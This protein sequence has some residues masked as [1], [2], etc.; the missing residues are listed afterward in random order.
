MQQPL[1]FDRERTE[2]T[3]SQSTS[4]TLLDALSD[5]P[6]NLVWTLTFVTSISGFLFGYDTGYI[7]SVLVSIGSDLN[8]K[9]LSIKQREYISSATSLG[10]LLSS[11]LT[12]FLADLIGR[13]FTLILSDLLF[14]IGALIQYFTYDLNEMIIGRLIMGFGVGLGSLC[15]PL[16]ISEL[17]PSKF[18]GRLVTI[19]C[20]AI[21]GG[22]L[23][24]YSIGAIFSNLSHGWRII[25]LLS[26]LPCIIQFISISFFLPDSPRYLI[27]KNKFNDAIIVLKKI[28]PNSSDSL[29][30]SNVEELQQLNLLWNNNDNIFQKLLSSWIELF[31]ISSN[32]RSLIIA[33][34]LQA[35]Q[36]FV[37]FNALMYFSSS[38][39]EL[40]GFKNSTFVSCF[41]AG[42]NFFTTIIALFIIDKIGRRKILLYSIPLLFSSQIICALSFA[43]IDINDINNNNNNIWKYILLISLIMFEMFYS[44]GLGNVPWQQS[45]L[46]P[47]K[48]RGLGSSLSTATNWFGSM[49]LSYFF[50]SLMNSISPSLTFLIFAFNTLISFIFIYYLYPELSGLQLEQVQDLLSDGFNVSKSINL[51]ND[52]L[53]G[54]QLINQH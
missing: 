2:S 45:E 1:S 52:S 42:T 7:S 47:Q 44:I 24:A 53:N 46:F 26:L 4:N 41:I 21:T 27:M 15:A 50:L 40:V 31:S 20:L 32:K 9:E 54:Y 39:F 29:I 33:C 28:Y 19:N 23:I 49:V 14:I 51:H 25:I 35:I 6:S 37:G 48:V 5:K 34:G 30:H 43:H 17:S 36:Q 13:K 10:A 3:A 38:I 16:Y 11:I 12:G 18:R 22:Q 8:G